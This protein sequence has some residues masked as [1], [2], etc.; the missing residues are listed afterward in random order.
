MRCVARTLAGLAV[1][2]AVGCAPDVVEH[3][4]RQAN[5]QSRVVPSELALR[6]QDIERVVRHATLRVRNR[7]CFGVGSGSGFAIAPHLLVTN[8]HVVQGADVLQVTTWDGNTL[9]VTV[10]G[11]AITNDLAVVVTTQTLKQTLTVDPSRPQPGDPI[12]AVGYP[13]G[14]RITFSD[15]EVIDHVPGELFG[16]TTDTMRVTADIIPGNSGGPLI[17]DTGEVV[18]VVFAIER[19]T[20]HGLVVPAG[21]LLDLLETREFY[22]NPSPC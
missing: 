12:T 6:S 19:E 14:G 8:R 22:V 7:T 15:G 4:P 1:L 3:Q 13:D 21:A 18:G 5:A 20:G 9:D 16:E 17:D 11:V 10:N 2:A